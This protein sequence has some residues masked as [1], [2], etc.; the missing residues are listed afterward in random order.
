MLNRRA[1]ESSMRSRLVV[2]VLLAVSLVSAVAFA[3]TGRVEATFQAFQASGVTGDAVLKAMPGGGTQI[4]AQL[5]G[6]VPNTE[7]I[8]SLYVGDQSCGTAGE[9]IVSFTSNSQGRA[10][11]NERVSEELIAIES[12]SV[13]LQS[14]NTLLACAPVD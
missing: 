3:Q 12:I 6:L 14:D 9:V 2:S 4:H 13:Q 8:S 11:W 1:K 10:V 7:Y 5:D